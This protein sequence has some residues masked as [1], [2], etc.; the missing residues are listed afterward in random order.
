MAPLIQKPEL[1]VQHC[2]SS[3]TP[4]ST[5]G[6][7]LQQ[8]CWPKNVQRFCRNSFAKKDNR[9]PANR[10]PSVGGTVHA[11]IC[12]HLLKNCRVARGP[13]IRTAPQVAGDYKLT[14]LLSS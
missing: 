14:T 5:I 1:P 8:A 7:K 10:E 12:L 4:T 13:S 6:W 3:T 2:R 11:V 9:P